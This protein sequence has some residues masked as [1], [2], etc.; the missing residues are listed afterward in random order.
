MDGK[1]RIKGLTS[2]SSEV[3]DLD[4]SPLLG[5]VSS[6][7]SANLGWLDKDRRPEALIDRFTLDLKVANNGKDC[8]Y[9]WECGLRLRHQDGGEY[10]V[11]HEI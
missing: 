3:E 6:E 1:G 5:S 7:F 2:A 8:R 11:W 10:S 9:R 4:D